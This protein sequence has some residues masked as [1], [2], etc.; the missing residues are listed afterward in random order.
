MY[1]SVDIKKKDSLDTAF[2]SRAICKLWL[3]TKL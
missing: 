2:L 1:K 3:M